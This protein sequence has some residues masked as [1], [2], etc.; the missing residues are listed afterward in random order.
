METR[1]LF[2][3]WTPHEYAH[4]PLTPA[5]ILPDDDLVFFLLSAV[6]KFDLSPIY[7]P[8]ERETRGA[9]PY[10]PTMMIILLMYSYSVGVFSSRKIAAACER[11]IAFITLV[12][13]QRPD[14][15][16]IS[17]FRKTHLEAF[18]A[19]FVEVLR[20]AGEL[21]MVK[22]GNIAIDGSKFRANAS[23]HKA[24]SYGYMQKERERLREE[25]A[26]LL[27]QA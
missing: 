13:Q 15:H 5:E 2:R 7:A 21:N 9:P 1:K 8:Y 16:T 17:D 18:T 14:F 20:L 23:R 11:N 10:D 19:L 22:L 6:P 27:K 12:G 25:V 3:P 4:Q 24:M 26:A